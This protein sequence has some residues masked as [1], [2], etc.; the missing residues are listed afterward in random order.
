MP[1]LTLTDNNIKNQ[2][3]L[4]TLLQND[5]QSQIQA[6][7][8]LQTIA[9]KSLQEL[10]KQNANLLVFPHCLDEHNNGIEELSI[11]ELVGNPKYDGDTICDVENVKVKT[12]NL[13]G[14]VGLGGNRFFVLFTKSCKSYSQQFA[15]CKSSILFWLQIFAATLSFDFAPSIYAIF[16][17]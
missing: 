5:V 2:P 13:M 7:Q 4:T 3:S 16:T 6:F 12:G 1:H 17:K 10:C 11:C 14:F 9:G 8:D 15:P